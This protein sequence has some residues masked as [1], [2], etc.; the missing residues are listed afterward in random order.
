MKQFVDGKLYDTERSEKVRELKG[1]DM[2]RTKKGRW[3]YCY[4]GN[5]AEFIMPA[6]EYEAKDAIGN[7]C[8]PEM[9]EKYFGKPEEA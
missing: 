3:F 1:A 2:Y 6:A 8:G 7:H 4:Y 9:Y 5:G